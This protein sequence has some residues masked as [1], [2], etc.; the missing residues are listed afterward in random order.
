MLI[1]ALPEGYP[2]QDG[3]VVLGG[4]LGIAVIIGWISGPAI[5]ADSA[6]RGGARLTIRVTGIHPD[7][8]LVRVALH[9]RGGSLKVAMH[10]RGGP[11]KVPLRGRSGQRCA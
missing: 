6:S 3:S 11:L 1:N 7:P 10:G 9:G 8:T 4:V 2:P 5:S